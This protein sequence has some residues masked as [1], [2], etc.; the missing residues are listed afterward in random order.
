MFK[1]DP[2]PIEQW[3]ITDEGE[4]LGRAHSKVFNTALPLMD[5][6]IAVL[7]TDDPTYCSLPD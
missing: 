1:G 6:S 5:T 4:I 2:L 3:T 7:I